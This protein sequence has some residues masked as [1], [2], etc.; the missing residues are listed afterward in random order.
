[1]GLYG[2]EP[3]ATRK[4]SYYDY[5]VRWGASPSH[6]WQLV[7]GG[8]TTRNADAQCCGQT[9]IDLYRIDPQAI[10]VRDIKANIDSIVASSTSNDWTW[11]DA[12]QM[13]MP[14]FAKLGVLY[15]D[16]KYF[17]KMHALYVDAK[18]TRGFYNT[19]D[20]LWWRDATFK[21]PFVTPGGKPSYWS[22]GNGW[23][24]A[25][26]VRVLDTIPVT[27][28][29]RAEYSA[30]FVAMASALRKAQRSDGFWNPSLADPNDFGG[31]ELTGT[32]LF[33]YGMAWG[34]RAGLL[35]AESYGPTL[36][37]AWCALESAIHADGALGYV[38][39][40]GSKPSDGQPVTYNSVPDYIDFGLGCLLLG[41]SEVWQLAAP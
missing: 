8:T 3:D 13:A 1:M 39:G 18:T 5:A 29:D 19:T 36:S 17:T 22:R 28:A 2:I 11:V 6:P 4:A 7:N 24:F 35:D 33:T 20:K 26:L 27:A 16:P 25:A 31:P 32:A 15:D 14:V 12:L 41:G 21:P 30:D 23:V 10:R 37:K 34:V 9:Y 40:T 38:Q